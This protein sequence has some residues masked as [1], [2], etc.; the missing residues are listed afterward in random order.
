MKSESHILFTDI[1][2]EDGYDFSETER[3]GKG[4]DGIL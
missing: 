1:W 4:D 2:W 3:E